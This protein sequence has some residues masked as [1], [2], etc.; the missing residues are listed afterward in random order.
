MRNSIPRVDGGLAFVA[1]HTRI[2]ND[3]SFRRLT[4]L[5]KMIYLVGLAEA[6]KC[7]GAIEM[8]VEA[9]ADFTGSRASDEDI[10]DAIDELINKNFWV[11]TGETTAS[12]RTWEKYQ[13]ASAQPAALKAMSTAGKA[14][15]LKRWHNAGK[16]VEPVEGCVL[17]EQGVK[18]PEACVKAPVAD[19]EP[20]EAPEV[21][22]AVKEA[23]EASEALTASEVKKRL[24]DKLTQQV[25]EFVPAFEGDGHWSIYEEWDNFIE[26]GKANHYLEVKG[27]TQTSLKNTLACH[28]AAAAW[29]EEGKNLSN[30]V[31]TQ[32][33]GLQKEYGI[34]VYEAI[35]KASVKENKFAYAKGILKNQSGDKK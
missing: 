33:K 20:T 13:S 22:K 24:T 7:R 9:V 8:T 34:N 1:L 30:G 6:G 23:S 3:R 31:F 35:W 2:L 19:L 21:Q 26:E 29:S 15:V 18:A 27:I 16:H 5:A 12:P 28:A 14:G 17:C 4:D 25:E 10:K 11:I 32:V